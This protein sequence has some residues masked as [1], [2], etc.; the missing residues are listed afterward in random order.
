VITDVQMPVMDGPAF[1]REIRRLDPHLK[2]ISVSGL[3]SEARLA[4]L[5]R[6][7]IAVVLGKP[8][9]AERLLSTVRQVLEGG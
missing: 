5:D 9:T 2:I 4:E 6:S 7:Q 8:Y 3:A 1:V